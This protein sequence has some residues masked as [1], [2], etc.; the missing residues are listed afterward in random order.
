MQVR[1]GGTGFGSGRGGVEGTGSPAASCPSSKSLS[2]QEA[3]RCTLA[4]SSAHNTHFSPP[5]YTLG[6]GPPR[7]LERPP[8]SPRP[9]APGGMGKPLALTKLSSPDLLPP[10]TP[11]S[12]LRVLEGKRGASC[13]S[14]GGSVQAVPLLPPTRQDTHNNFTNTTPGVGGLQ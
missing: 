3:L 4:C 2:S 10:P 6:D 5:W 1:A 12:C 14:G 9:G 7:K 8:W 13:M 11:Q